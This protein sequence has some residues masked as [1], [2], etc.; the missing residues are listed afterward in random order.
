MRVEL[1]GEGWELV[2]GFRKTLLKPLPGNGG[3]EELRWILRRRE[4]VAR[5][6]VQVTAAAPQVGKATK[7]LELPAE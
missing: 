4:E 2:Q 5:L 1:G 6:R 3:R 7:T